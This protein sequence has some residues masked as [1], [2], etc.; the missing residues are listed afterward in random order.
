MYPTTFHPN[1]IVISPPPGEHENIAA[2]RV[3]PVTYGDG[4]LSFVSAWLPTP[5]DI[6]NLQAGKPI[7]L[8][9]LSNSLPPVKLSTNPQ[10]L[11]IIE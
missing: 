4:S 2:L 5:E 7:Y 6:E 11:G 10:E 3:V 8:G 9:V 1:E